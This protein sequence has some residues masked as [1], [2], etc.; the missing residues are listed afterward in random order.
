MSPDIINVGASPNDGQGD[1]IRTAFIKTNSNFAELFALPNP[2]PPTTLVGQ[3][4]DVPGMY[5]Y[6]A[7]YFYYCFATWDGI[8]TIWARVAQV[9]YV[10]VNKINNGNSNVSINNANANVTVTVNSTNIATFSTIGLS[11]NGN[12]IG[13]YF[14]GDGSQL[15]NIVATYGNAN[16]A[17]YIPTYSGNIGSLTVIGNVKTLSFF[18]GDGSQLSNITAANLVGAYSNANVA[19]YLPTFSGNITGGNIGLSGNINA[20][21]DVTSF[22]NIIAAPGGYFQ[23]DGSQ[24]TGIVPGNYSNANV[25]DYLPTYSGDISAAV[26]SATGNITTN[27]FFLGTFIGNI[28]GNLV[29]PGASTQVLYNFNGNAGASP[30]LTFNSA[31]NVLASTGNISTTGNII[32]LSVYTSSVISAAGNVRGSNFNT[33]GNVSAA[34]NIYGNYFVGNVAGAVANAIFANTANVAYSV[35]GSNVSGSVANAIY[36]NTANTAT[37]ATTVLGPAQINITSL[38]TLTELS[39]SGN[40]VAGGAITPTGTFRLPSY[41]TTQIANIAA[42]PGDM[43]Y[44]STLQIVQAYQLIPNTVSTFGWV[45]WTVAVYQ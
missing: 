38:G 34:G 3:A 37:S 44:N 11:V 29:V 41:S 23:G 40:V 10:S 36:A 43:V 19:N 16:V 24:L 32:S 42:Q 15:T 5:A 1:P 21:G 39:V 17:N 28:S 8:S 6:N 30:G 33:V 18:V 4:G 20:V 7:D 12:V 35:S 26:I 45:S 25:A 27:G 14:I 13:N 31:S 9:N 22:A 2:T